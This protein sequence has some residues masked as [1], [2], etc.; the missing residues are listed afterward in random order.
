MCVLALVCVVLCVKVVG[1]RKR[2]H[3]SGAILKTV[4][5]NGAQTSEARPLF[6]VNVAVFLWAVTTK[7]ASCNCPKRAKF[8]NKLKATCDCPSEDSVDER[9]HIRTRHASHSPSPRT[10][11]AAA[12]LRTQRSFTYTALL[13]LYSAP[14]RTHPVS[15]HALSCCQPGPS[16]AAILTCAATLSCAAIL[17]CAAIPNLRRHPNLHRHPNLRRHPNLPAPPS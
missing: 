1:C 14:S 13:H 12:L 5:G 3:R 10:A 4:R 16:C 2:P 17:T 9:T 11:A 6:S 7:T 15:H 8:T